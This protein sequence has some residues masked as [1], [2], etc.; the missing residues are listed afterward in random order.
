MPQCIGPR[1]QQCSGG[2]RDAAFGSPGTAYP[3][4]MRKARFTFSYENASFARPTTTAAQAHAPAPAP[5]GFMCVYT[6]SAEV[7]GNL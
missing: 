4:R 7:S 5:S 2:S 1:K 3:G 6:S